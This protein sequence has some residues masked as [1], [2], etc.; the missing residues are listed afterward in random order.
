MSS[1]VCAARLVLPVS[2][3]VY[4]FPLDLHP[5]MPKKEST[6]GRKRKGKDLDQIHEDLQPEKKAKLRSQPIDLDL[7]GEGQHYC[8]ECNRYF[9]DE[10]TQLKHAK[11]K[12][13]KQRLRQL[14]EPAYTQAE[15]DA[16]GGL[17]G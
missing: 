15:A 5:K 14:K 10:L 6:K 9:T 8:V 11:S 4:L 13:H 12:V 16:A 3:D 1:R 7:P 2:K 17:G